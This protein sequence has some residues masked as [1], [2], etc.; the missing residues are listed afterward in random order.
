MAEPDRMKLAFVYDAVYPYTKGGV[1]K[2]LSELAIRL[3]GKGHEVHLF[4]LKF[5]EGG[6]TL[7]KDGVIL[8]GVCPARPLYVRG[9]RAINE[10]VIFGTCLLPALSRSRFDLVDCQQF[11]F[12]SCFA[13]KAVAAVRRT[14][15]VITWHEFWGDS[16][17]AY[18][19]RAGLFGKGIERLVL[20]LTPHRVAVSATTAGALR[21]TGCA[22]TVAIIPNG[23]DP[24]HIAAITPARESSDIIV[25]CRL[26][27]EK[28]ID[29]LVRAFALLAA[30][31]PDLRLRIIGEGPEREFLLRLIADLG[32]SE[33]VSVL[34]FMADHDSLIA[35]LKASK[36]FALP[37][38][39]EGF[40]IT[41]LE[42]LACGLPVVTV[43]HPANAI[44]EL[45][46]EKTGFLCQTDP[47]DLAR[48]IREALKH[49]ADLRTDC[50]AASATY[51]WDSI[52]AQCE[53]YYRSVLSG[54]R[55]GRGRGR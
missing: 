36:V 21:R 45:V 35:E 8:H 54:H 30:G 32:L 51:G 4:G 49:S 16:W 23:I 18:L 9:R 31:Q 11:P 15:L 5:W 47:N 26:I 55:Q 24:A 41:A 1:E 25:A 43:D 3:S 2:R 20:R 13:A 6:D 29:L 42:A 44:R 46:T 28:N 48:G 50:I 39:R 17:Y 19:G 7:T 38:T 10:A 12:F 33:N 22:R 40:G 53:D 14:P 37:S 27:R 34:N 52:A